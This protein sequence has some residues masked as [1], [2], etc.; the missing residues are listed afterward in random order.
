[1]AALKLRSVGALL[2]AF[3]HAVKGMQCPGS[4]SFI[5]AG[6]SMVVEASAACTAVKTEMKA[7]ISGSHG[8]VDPHNGGVY[9][10]L[11]DKDTQLSTQRTTNPKTSIGGK[12]YTDKQIFTFEAKG[13]DSCD[14]QACSESQGMSVYDANTNYCNL[15]NLLCGDAQCKPITSF[16]IKESKVSPNVGSGGADPSKCAPAAQEILQ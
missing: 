9:T 8:W 13:A 12:V 4:S 1:M 7:R 5:H 2:L 10:L 14:I 11:E 16:E 3:A 15:H 6:L